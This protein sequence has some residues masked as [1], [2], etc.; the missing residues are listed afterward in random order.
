IGDQIILEENYDESYIP[1]EQEVR[2]YAWEIGINPEKEPELI[3]LA[4]EGI[5]APLPPQWKP[6]QDTNGD[7]YYFNFATGQSMWDHPCDIQYRELVLRE[8][9]K[10]LAQG[11]LRRKE[12]KKKKDK[13]EK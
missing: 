13:R 3:W 9:E 5:M 10:L 2:N 4:R 12:K 7:L 8:R 6:C 11:P 1:S